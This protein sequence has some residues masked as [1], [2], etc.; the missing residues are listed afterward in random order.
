MSNKQLLRTA[1]LALC[2]MIS[3]PISATEN[4]L[5]YGIV[6][7]KPAKRIKDVTPLLSHLVEQFEPSVYSSHKVH[8]YPN[9]EKL[10]SAILAGEI[11]I[12]SSTLYSALHYEKHSGTQIIASRW[13]KGAKSYRSVFVTKNGNS[14]DSLDAL[15]GKVVG[16]ESR[17][18]TSSYF[19]PA[20]TL[21]ENGM[22]LQ[23]LSSPRETPDI[24][25]VGYLFFEDIMA[26]SDELN[27]SMWAAK[28]LVDSIAFSSSNWNSSKD[29]PTAIKKD[30]K[31]FYRTEEYPRALMSVS[32]TMPSA[33]IDRIQ[34]V[35]FALD[36]NQDGRDILSQYQT[37]TK[38]TPL[39]E[40]VNKKVDSARLQLRK[41]NPID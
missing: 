30:L 41:L 3:T 23:P 22:K 1:T 6:S 34:Q 7:G 31:I 2:C 37:T 33:T 27:L 21:L 18:S 17:E 26:H 9:I 36:S 25:S 12:I 8:V 29:T 35:I 15:K 24:D 19:L 14:I 10:N 5:D 32:A 28:G 13:K 40:D 11:D 16:F 38:F 20:V 39:D 4:R